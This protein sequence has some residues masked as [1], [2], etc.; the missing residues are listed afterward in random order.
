MDTTTKALAAILVC[1]IVFTALFIG[2]TLRTP[3]NTPSENQTPQDDYFDCPYAPPGFVCFWRMENTSIEN[4]SFLIDMYLLKVKDNTQTFTVAMA[5]SAFLNYL[6]S[7]GW[8]LAQW[9]ENFGENNFWF[10][11]TK[12]AENLMVSPF[13]DDGL[14]GDAGVVMVSLGLMKPLPPATFS[15]VR[16]YLKEV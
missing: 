1:G 4:L 11:M 13:V 3:V 10:A 2:L 12:G 14:Y 9:P 15:P 8:T 7:A 5:S 16:G 6:Q